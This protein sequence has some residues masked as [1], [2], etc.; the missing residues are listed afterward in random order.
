MP[1]GAFFYMMPKH[2]KLSNK[3]HAYNLMAVDHDEI[4]PLDFY[5]ISSG[6][7]EHVLGSNF[8]ELTHLDRWIREIHQFIKLRTLLTF[9]QFRLRKQYTAWR[10]TV[11]GS[12]ISKHTKQLG[13]RSFLDDAILQ[14]ALLKVRALCIDAVELQLVKINSKK[15]YT[16]HAF[17]LAQHDQVDSVTGTLDAFRQNVLDIVMAACVALLNDRGFPTDEN[18]L[19]I[20]ILKKKEDSES[21]HEWENNKKYQKDVPDGDS[22]S[23]TRIAI[24]RGIC[25]RLTSFIRLVD[26]LVAGAMQALA[27][28]SVG[29]LKGHMCGLESNATPTEAE[30]S[31]WKAEDAERAAREEAGEEPGTVVK[32]DPS[33]TDVEFEVFLVKQVGLY[34]TTT[35][36]FF[37]QVAGMDW[38]IRSSST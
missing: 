37:L 11:I 18:G 24:K 30:E 35:T 16:L 20:I 13:A 1:E 6:G 3:H 2:G 36:R 27:A 22:M 33:M 12:R 7:V 4:D 8:S 29:I 38:L 10:K 14:P 23:Y 19:E 9:S 5:T 26:L 21:I 34:V 28:E 17:L 32:I 25:D 15:T 31:V